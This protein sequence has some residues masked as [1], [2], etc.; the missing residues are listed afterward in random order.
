MNEEGVEID[1]H[2]G[3]LVMMKATCPVILNVCG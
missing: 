3:R 2:Q 1:A